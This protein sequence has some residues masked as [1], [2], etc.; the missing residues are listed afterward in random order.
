MVGFGFFGR[1]AYG[2]EA[3]CTLILYCRLSNL[4]KMPYCPCW[5]LAK[6]SFAVL[7]TWNH[8]KLRYGDCSVWFLHPSTFSSW[9]PS[10]SCWLPFLP[11]SS[12]WLFQPQGLCTCSS[13]CLCHFA[14]SF[15]LMSTWASCFTSSDV[16][17]WKLF[18]TSATIKC[19]TCAGVKFTLGFFV[20]LFDKG[21]SL[22]LDRK[23]HE[24]KA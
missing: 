6:S 12:S 5:Y 20:W 7:C 24:D 10:Q 17:S 19:G 16:F 2:T 14:F 11:T 1:T 9:P 23:L 3:Q 15:W 22:S 13:W 18:L 21:L 4:F 8:G